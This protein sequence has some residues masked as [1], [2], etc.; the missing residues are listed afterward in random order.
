[1]I[2]PPIR[3]IAPEAVALIALIAVKPVELGHTLG[4][5]VHNSKE[6]RGDEV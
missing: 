1:M 2:P 5:G 6:I 3:R 4:N